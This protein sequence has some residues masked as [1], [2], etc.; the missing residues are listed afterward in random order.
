MIHGSATSAA[1]QIEQDLA[2]A[3]DS[4]K[5]M[6]A[7]WHAD[8]NGNLVCKRTTWQFPYDR[9]SEAVGLLDRIFRD[10]AT[11]PSDP[12]PLADFLTNRSRPLPDVDG[13]EEGGRPCGEL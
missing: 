9:F 11:P 12:L 10:E 6:V 2:A 7:I 8:S 4:D 3:R 5:F 13:Q 1:A